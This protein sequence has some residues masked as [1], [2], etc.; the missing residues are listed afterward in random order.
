MLLDLQVREATK[1]AASLRDVFLWMNQNY[2]RKG[3][4]FPDSEGVQHAA[5][6]VSHTDLG[7]FFQ[8][9]VAGT[10]E[11]P[12]DNFFETVGLHLARGVVSVADLGFVPV[13]NLTPARRSP[14]WL[15]AERRSAPDWRLGTRSWRSMARWPV[16]TFSSASPNWALGINFICA[17]ATREEIGT[18]LETRP[19][20]RNQF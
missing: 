11:I 7:W 2:A 5:E 3:Q 12:W 18:A 14:R 8:K 4:F 19:Q 16:R 15:R 1:D 17:C 20:G 13:R 9:Y 6:V 10:E